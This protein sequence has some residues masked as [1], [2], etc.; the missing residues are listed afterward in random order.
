MIRSCIFDLDGT[1]LD[2]LGGICYHVNKT[3][4]AYGI[5]PI[6]VEEC[7][8]FVGGG[9][10][11]L[12]ELSLSARDA[13][14][15]ELYER[16]YD[17]YIASYDAA[18]YKNVYV[19]DGIEELLDTLKSSGIRLAVLSNKPHSS[20]LLTVEKFFPGIFD[21][22]FG[23]RSDKPLKPDPTAAREI[24]SSFEISASEC[25]FIGDSDTDILTGKNLGAGITVGV[26]WGYRER[27]LLLSLGADVTVKN[28]K[29]IIE[30]IKEI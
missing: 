2:T 12:I 16:V 1:L 27:E 15:K 18:P 7:R 20:T 30:V 14:T 9:A 6:S 29:E 3:L 11:K 26:E 10:K 19:Y 5:L 17:S 8:S 24:L 4:Q 25:A 21:I 13:Y 23:G 28:A 22:V